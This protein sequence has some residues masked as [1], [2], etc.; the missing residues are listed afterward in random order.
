MPRAPWVVG[1]CFSVAAALLIA[2]SGPLLLF[3]PAFVSFEQARTGVPARLATTQPEV[4]RVTASVL[5][6]LWSGGSFAASLDGREPLLDAAER[7]HM[8]DVGA[9]VRLLATLVLIAL[10]TLAISALV[11]RREPRRIGRLLLVA[12][13]TIGA[14]AIVLAALFAVAFDQAFLAFHQ[15]FF[16]Q[17][18]F[19]FSADSRLIRLFPEPFWFDAALA[20]GVTIVAAASV[21]SL[22]GALLLRRGARTRV[23]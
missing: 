8:R 10:L 17:G 7:S 18:N 22:A 16:P 4:D 2:L 12:A 5:A 11:L 21:A 23:G 1:A 13:A 14:A 15:V 20:A 19:L 9:L 3:N 6:D